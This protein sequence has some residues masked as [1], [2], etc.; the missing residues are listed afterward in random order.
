MYIRNRVCFIK[1]HEKIVTQLD[2]IHVKSLFDYKGG[3]IVGA[4]FNS[5]KAA[6]SAFVFMISSI[7]SQFKEVVH[8]MP[9][10]TINF[11]L[12]HEMIRK[13]VDWKVWN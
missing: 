13:V 4:V 11:S 6:T 1:D 7:L 3:S 10:H 2:E 12:L 5:E 8:I 9:V